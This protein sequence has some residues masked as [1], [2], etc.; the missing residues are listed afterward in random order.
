MVRDWRKV[1]SHACVGV[2]QWLDP[3]CVQGMIGLV[4]ECELAL[5]AGVPILQEFALALKRIS[6]GKRLYERNIAGSGYE[7][8]LKM[9]TIKYDKPVDISDEARLAFEEAFDT[10][11]WEQLHVEEYLRNWNPDL[12]VREVGVELDHRWEDLTCDSMPE[13]Y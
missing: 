5:S 10:P 7:C 1:L 2:K 13:L 4:G 9:E 8:R 3:T 12:E 6:A 11:I